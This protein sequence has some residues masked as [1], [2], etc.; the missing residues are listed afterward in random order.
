MQIS[1]RQTKSVVL[2][3]R[4]DLHMHTTVSDGIA[5]VQEMLAHVAERGTL[6][7]LAITDHDR[8]D[9]SLWAYAHRDQYP[10]EII[11]GLEVTS[12]DG[13]LLA[14]W[15]TEMVPKGMSLRETC[16]AIHEQNGL[17]II[18][19]PF[20]P[21]IAPA[22]S[23]RYFW[24]PKVLVESGVDAVEVFNAGAFTPGSN[25]LAACVFRNL[26]LPIVGN[27]DAH[28]PASI[29]TGITRFVGRTADDL[30]TSIAQGLTAAEGKPWGLTVYLKLS[31]IMIPK[32]LNGSLVTNAQSTR[33]TLT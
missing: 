25:W 26:S 23:W 7:V 10:F 4:A 22:A 12:R 24:H 18:A 5:S 11:P 16:A 20:E 14:L 6:D 17:A 21:T 9:A 31:R 8:L 1:R 19:H 15:C 33:P 3:G 2:D 28:M 29:G 27:S 30:R 32:K 13:H